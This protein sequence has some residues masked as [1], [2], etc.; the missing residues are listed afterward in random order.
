[1]NLLHHLKLASIW[2]REYR[3]V[4]AEFASYSDRELSADLRLHL[5]DTPGIAAEA[6]DQHVAAFVRDNP[7]YRDALAWRTGQVATGWAV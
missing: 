2:R 1:M 7:A 6:A 4:L 3:R 5:S